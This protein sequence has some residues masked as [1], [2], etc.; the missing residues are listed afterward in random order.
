MAIIGPVEPF[1]GGIAKHTTQLARSLNAMP[2]I[3][4]RVVSFSQ[5][6]PSWLYPGESDLD[7]SSQRPGDLTIDYM[8]HALNPIS[9]RRVA[10]DLNNWGVEEIIIPAWT[11]FVAPCLGMIARQCKK[12]GAH[13]SMVVHNSSDHEDAKWKT[14]F[15]AYQLSGADSFLTHNVALAEALKISYPTAQVCR[16]AHPIYDQYPEPQNSLTS[17]AGLELLFFGFVRPYKGVDI[18]VNALA[19]SGVKD[20][21]LTIAGE[22]WQRRHEIDD[23]VS[24]L[25]LADK[26]EILNRYVSDQEAAELFARADVVV[27]PYRSVSGTGIIPLA[28]HYE[29]PVIVTD[30]P[31]LREFVTDGVTGWVVPPEAPAELAKLI[32]GPLTR[33]AAQEMAPAIKAQKK[34]MSWENYSVGLM[35][36]WEDKSGNHPVE[37][38]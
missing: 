22:C 9:W 21:R 8:L 19:Q 27:L 38:V 34:K 33:K 15:N 18:A 3:D 5:L 16:R 37:A 11:F 29:K 31:G 14:A 10:H 32:N 30:L 26:V 23:L 12:N 4:L 7:N 17:R 1:R 6:Y 20:V 28:Y 13:V 36:L 25:G 2:N 24:D 35:S